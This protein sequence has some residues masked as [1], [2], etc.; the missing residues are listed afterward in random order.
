MKENID[1]SDLLS[2]RENWPQNI[3]GQYVYIGNFLQKLQY[4]K[5]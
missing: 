1:F 2:F 4:H 3:C 5:N